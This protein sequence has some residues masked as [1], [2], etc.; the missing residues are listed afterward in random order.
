M[1]DEVDILGKVPIFSS[2]E[3]T[4]LERLATLTHRH[5]FHEGDVIIREGEHDRRLFVT[6]SGKVEVIKS[7]GTKSERRLREFGPL[8]YFG[9]MALIDDLARSASVVATEET[10]VLSLDHLDLRQEIEK[11][12]AV[13]F[14]LLRML[15]QRIRSIEENM[16]NLLNNFLPSLY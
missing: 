7:L 10:E 1:T 11:Y 6:V 9:E 2:V 4:D 15:S 8:S 14:E 5:L 12:P 16:M 3:K 13:A